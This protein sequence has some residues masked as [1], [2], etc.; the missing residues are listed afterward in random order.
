M[1][2]QKI[3]KKLYIQNAHDHLFRESMQDIEIA[4]KIA[5]LTLPSSIGHSINWT[6]LDIVKGDWIDEKLKEHRSD[7]LYRA[8]L[9]KTDQWLYLLFEHKSAPDKKIHKKLLR[10]MVEIW[11]QHEKQD[12]F[13]KHLPV[14]I[15]IIIYHGKAPCN[16]DNSIKPLF[17][18]IE[19]IE[20][21]VPDFRKCILDLSLFELE[22]IEDSKLKMLL[23]AL[24]Y[25]R[26]PDVLRVLPQIIRI[27]EKVQNNLNHYDYLKVVLTYLGSLINRSAIDEFWKII[28]KEHIGGEAYMETIADALREEERLKRKKIEKE[29]IVL[30]KEIE[31]KSTELE[32]K[33]T[34]LEQKSTELEQ[35]STELEQKSTELEQKSTELEQRRTELEQKSADLEQKDNEIKQKEELMYQ[36]IQRMLKKEIDLQSIREITGLSIEKIVQIKKD[37]N[38]NNI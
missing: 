27:S 35:K 37:F 4:R 38:K 29:I 6:M 17:A 21:F 15:P 36:I 24:K 30:R 12:E 33:S 31:Q 14:V 8:R 22:N 10:Y 18:I 5:F 11:D 16:F 20:E 23:L 7:V 2:S 26:R 32:Q 3:T 34:E 13:F 25:S 28:V 9:L 1:G 19:E